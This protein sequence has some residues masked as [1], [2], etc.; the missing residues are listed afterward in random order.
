MKTDRDLNYRLYLQK[1]DGFTR[2]PFEQ[3]LKFY[4]TIQSGDVEGIRELYAAA[5]RNF[6][7]GKG[8]LSSDPVRNIM[9][10]F[11]TAVA[12]IARF[13]VEDGLPHDVA[14]T[15]SDIYIQ[16]ADKMNDVNAILDL[17]GDMQIDFAE[18]MKKLKKENVISLHVRRCI[19]Y[20]YEHLHEELTLNVLSEHVG[21]NPSYLSKLFSKETGM[22][23]K[24][25]VIR[26]K[27]RTAENLLKNSDFSCLDI[28]L[29][30]GFSSQSAFIST[31][32]K[33]VGM[34]PKKYRELHYMD[35]IEDIGG[36][37]K[38]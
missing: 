33:Q 26:E 37:K 38:I 24:S 12:L 32:R 10:H 14:Y 6:A 23:V 22:S 15:L 5:R 13:C 31:F 30:L 34:T 11:V 4:R 1:N 35:V 21:L 29:A 28:S 2:N 36:K 19:D 18:R 25:F 8:T 27:V 16:R 9:Y 7:E 20:I 17:L 3:E